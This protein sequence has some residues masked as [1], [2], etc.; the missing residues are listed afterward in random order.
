LLPV[1]QIKLK[2]LA[3]LNTTFEAAYQVSLR[4]IWPF[5]SFSALL[6][7]VESLGNHSVSIQVQPWMRAVILRAG[8]KDDVSVQKSLR[9]EVDKESTESLR[10]TA[11]NELQKLQDFI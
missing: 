8:E 5:S 1:R 3:T 4:Q 11:L 6:G 2:I 7:T 9:E 10:D